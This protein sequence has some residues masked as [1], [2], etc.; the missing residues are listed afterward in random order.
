MI[1]SNLC[2]YIRA[3]RDI[4]IEQDN[5]KL[6]SIELDHENGNIVKSSILCLMTIVR[7]VLLSSNI[8]EEFKNY[9][10]EIPLNLLLTLQQSSL[11]AQ[12]YQCFRKALIVG[13]YFNEP[14]DDKYRAEL[15][16]R[17]KLID[18]HKFNS[19]VVKLFIS[20]IEN[21]NP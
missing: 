14:D 2:D 1:V 7:K 8:N 12:Y 4:P 17:A 10:I 6:K 5:V 20:D 16:K 13:G 19:D 3:I 9:L 15:S 21:N 18:T 11:H